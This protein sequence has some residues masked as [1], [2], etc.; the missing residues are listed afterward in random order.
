MG[1]WNIRY[2]VFNVPKEKLPPLVEPGETLGRI[3]KRASQESG[4]PEGLRVIAAGSDKGCETLGGGCVDESMASLSFGTTCREQTGFWCS[5]IGGL[6][7]KRP[8]QRAP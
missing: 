3:S 5:P 1:K 2:A 7:L 4:L 8:K 6:G